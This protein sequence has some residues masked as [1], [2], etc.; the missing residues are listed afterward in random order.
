M[1]LPN[2]ILVGA[3]Q[4]GS[5][6]LWTYLLH[7]PEVFVPRIK[8]PNYF[9]YESRSVPLAGPGDLQRGSHITRDWETY[10]KLFDGVTEERRAKRSASTR[11]ST[12]NSS[13]P[14]SCAAPATLFM[15]NQTS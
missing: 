6:S 10:V 11:N 14:A 8:E 9:A 1:T 15:F 5:T 3:S 4:A 2:F 13:R 12:K 7:H